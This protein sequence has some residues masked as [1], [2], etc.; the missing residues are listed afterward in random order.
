MAEPIDILLKQAAE[1]RRES[2]PLDAKRHLSAAID[3]LRQR[4]GDWRLAPALREQG[5]VERNLHDY[6]AAHTCYEE[7]IAIYRTISQPL[8]LAHTIRHLG[9]VYRQMGKPQLAEPCY[10]EALALYRDHPE[11]PPLDLANAIRSMA[12]L[13]EEIGGRELAKALWTEARELY[14]AV[15]ISAGVAESERRMALLAG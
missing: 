1:A 3:Q 10:R 7:A 8:K 12:L 14:A 15:D 4:P 5:E 9:D 2:R 11:A 13:Q 6:D